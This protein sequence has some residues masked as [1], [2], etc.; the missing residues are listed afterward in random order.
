M[1][2]CGK[3]K[4]RERGGETLLG[5][6]RRRGVETREKEKETRARVRIERIPEHTLRGEGRKRKTMQYE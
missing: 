1:W 6:G 3:G 4:E 5:E 2:H